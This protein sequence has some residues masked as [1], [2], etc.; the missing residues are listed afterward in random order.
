MDDEQTTIDALPTEA[1]I[2]GLAEETAAAV[3]PELVPE[4]EPEP[5]PNKPKRSKKAPPPPH[6]L[7]GK[8]VTG[9]G[10][11]YYLIDERGKRRLIPSMQHF[12]RM[13]VRPVIR[14]PDDEL[15]AM[16]LGWDLR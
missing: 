14:L 1:D 5:K 10:P 16:P 13:G 6:P 2:A 3:E 9:S 7:A 4:P 8:V 12:Y 15:N 11:A